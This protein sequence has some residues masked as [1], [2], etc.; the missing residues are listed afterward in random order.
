MAFRFYMYINGR[1]Y[2]YRHLLN[3]WKLWFQRAR[4]DIAMKSTIPQERPP[5]Q[6]HVSCNFCGKSIS[7]FMQGLSRTRV[8]FRLGTTPNKLKVGCLHFSM[9]LMYLLNLKKS[10]GFSSMCFPIHR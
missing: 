5:Q 2:S 3:A 9:Y 10:Q 8:P 7:A 4:F 1:C 6:I